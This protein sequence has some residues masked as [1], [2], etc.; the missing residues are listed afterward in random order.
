MPSKKAVRMASVSKLEG[1]DE[2]QVQVC[3][4]ADVLA[5]PSKG[6]IGPGLLHFR[7]YNWYLLGNHGA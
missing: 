1:W 7:G 3:T 2:V 6:G 5:I 4:C